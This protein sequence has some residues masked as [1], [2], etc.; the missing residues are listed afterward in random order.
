MSDQAE[1][2]RQRMRKLRDPIKD[3]NRI[4]IVGAQPQAKV[5]LFS[6]NLAKALVHDG[7]PIII[8]K[9]SNEAGEAHLNVI[10]NLDNLDEHH[11]F[12]K[13][14]MSEKEGVTILSLPYTSSRSWDQASAYTELSSFFGKQPS[15]AQTLLLVQ[16]S[17]QES[18]FHDKVDPT[19]HLIVTKSE[20]TDLVSAYTIIKGLH[21][22]KK[23]APIG[24]VVTQVDTEKQAMTAYETLNGVS[25]R[26]LEKSLIYCGALTKGHGESGPIA[27][28]WLGRGL[29]TPSIYEACR[30]FILQEK[31]TT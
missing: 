31:V 25:L 3:M 9:E 20:P 28:D 15:P 19:C 21:S 23:E 8:E 12:E 18:A 29:Q 30:R 17:F 7:A 6:Y 2:L 13:A 10:L 1:K 14:S 26:F 4:A 11:L 16:Y 24:I 22:K 27:A 5:A